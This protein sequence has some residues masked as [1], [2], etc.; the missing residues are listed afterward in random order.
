MIETFMTSF[1]RLNDKAI[2]ESRF[3]YKDFTGRQLIVLA[4]LYRHGKT[5]TLGDAAK[6]CGGTY[7]NAHPILASLERHGLL[8]L[9]ENKIDRRKI[10]VALTPEGKAFACEVLEH[11]Y[12]VIEGYVKRLSEEEMRTFVKVVDTVID[13]GG[14]ISSFRKDS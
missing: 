3:R 10:D 4:K 8:T 14:Y 6:I 5:T 13:E 12:G 9:T 1:Q 7:Q 2:Q 11:L